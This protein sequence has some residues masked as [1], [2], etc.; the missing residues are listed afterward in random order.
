MLGTGSW[1]SDFINQGALVLG[2][3]EYFEFVVDTTG[4][5]SI[6]LDFAARRTSQ[7]A[8]SIQLY[9]GPITGTEFAGSIY[10]LTAANTWFTFGPTT[11]AANLNPAGNTRF[12][13]Y[14][15]NSGQ[16]NNGHSIFIDGV[17]F[18]GLFCSPVIPPPPVPGVNPP[19]ISKSFSPDPIG[20]G[21]QSTLTFVVSNPN[22][23]TP[24]SGIAVSD[25][26]PAGLIAVPGTFGGS[27]TGFWNLDPSDSSVM[28]HSGGALAG[29]ASCT[30]TVDVIASTV[31]TSLNISDLIYST[32]S[33]YNLDLTTGVAQAA[34][35]VLD[36]PIIAKTFDPNL[37]L[38]G[39]TPN[40]AAT[41][42]F[43]LTNPNQSHAVGGVSF[44]DTYP[45]GLIVAT[46]PNASTTGCG[47][48][49]W[50]PI[51]SAGSVSFSGGSIAA[52]GACVVTVDVT[53]P[54]GAYPNTSSPVSHIVGGVPSTNG[55]T[56][57]AT[58][59][60]DAPIPGLALLKEV[61]LSNDPDAAWSDYLAV[62]P[63]DSVYYK[64]TVENI[65][66]VPLSGIAVSDP[67]VDISSCTW[68]AG[69][70]VADAGCTP[71][72][73]RR[74][75]CRAGDGDYRCADKHGERSDDAG[76]WTDDQ[77]SDLRNCCAGS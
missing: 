3:N 63:S 8:Q 28:L 26:L 1:S 43:T 55:S 20:V 46:P 74:V 32:E 34:L 24:L 36:P 35:D 14:A 12:R 40:D 29:G 25:E 47:V 9:Y 48:P 37:V 56:A 39:V 77:L 13:L 61:G 69:L 65:G 66:E 62:E 30:L 73:H 57:S 44:S 50:A 16:N 19:Q 67:S 76:A 71:G 33:G 38:L 45:V 4:I 54:A 68:P 22:P 58:V 75:R 31:G 21:Q 70:P 60:I 15:S 5:D 6:T 52:G 18:R 7:G 42:S 53:G 11:I 51:A 41:L 23:A 49:T 27:C 2:N 10:S 17:S 59:V 72:S 64:L